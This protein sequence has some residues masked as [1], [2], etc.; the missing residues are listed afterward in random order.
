MTKEDTF[1]DDLG[2]GII[3]FLLT[4]VLQFIFNTMLGLPASSFK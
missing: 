2:M 3:Q 1:L 4:M